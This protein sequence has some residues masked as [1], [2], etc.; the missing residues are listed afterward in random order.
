MTHPGIELLEGKTVLDA[1]T[2]GEVHA[3]AICALNA[4]YP[5]A[6]AVTAIMDL[7]V[8]AEAFG[9]EVAFSK[10]E[11][12]NI[13]GRLVCDYDSVSALEIPDL[14]EGRIGEYLKA[15]RLTRA[16]ITDKPIYGG[17]IGP[18]SLAGRLYDLSE[19]MM[20]IY[21]EPDTASLLLDK[22]TTFIIS[23]LTAMKETGIDGVILAEPSAGLLSDDDCF[24][25]S[26]VYVKKIIDAVEDES[27]TVILHN[28]GN[29]GHC[30]GAMV[31]SEASMLHFGNRADMVEALE[32]CPATVTVMGNI[33]P[34]V[35][36]AQGTPE[37]VGAAV[38][39]LL[40]ATAGYPNFVLSTGCDVPPHI[41][42]ANIEAF[43]SELERFNSAQL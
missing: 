35:V 26:S 10:D 14:S 34:V 5:D 33:D 3:D 17:A 2:D 38:R 30:T 24:N 13:T 22:C 8:E 31:G 15:N 4:R 9:A 7:T 20:A 21:I 18:F 28:C 23:Y 37:T 19:M 12:P 6:A 39:N 11:I 1:V 29:T 36:L 27:F 43:Y 40:E 41:P 16:R 32:A 42:S 25:W